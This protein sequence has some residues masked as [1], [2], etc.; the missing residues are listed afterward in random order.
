MKYIIIGSS[1]GIGKKIAESL[2]KNCQLILCSRNI[3]KVK[4]NFIREKPLFFKF[5]ANNTRDIN[6]LVKFTKLKFGKIDGI[7]CCQGILGD[8]GDIYNC[9]IKKWFEIFNLNFKSNLVIIRN[10]FKLIRKYQFSKI[11]FFTGGGA[12]NTFEKFSAYS[13]S[14]TALVRFSENLAAELKKYKIMVN[15]VSPGFIKTNIHKKNYKNLNKLSKK[16]MLLL[17]TNKNIKPNYQN[18]VGLINFLIKVKNMNLSGKTI[19]ANFDKWK[20]KNFLAKLKKNNNYL[21]LIRKN[22]YN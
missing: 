15:C 16:Y 1:Q 3:E 21:T 19:S 20:N 8:P 9:N 5:D 18:I 7:I 14:K 17:K 11:I 10:I 4:K 6:R 22:I 2:I 12:F 13:V